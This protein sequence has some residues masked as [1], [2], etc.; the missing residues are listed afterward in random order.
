MPIYEYQCEE[1]DADFELFIRSLSQAAAPKCP[2]CGS[3]RV[4]KAISLFGVGRTSASGLGASC[5]PG[6][7]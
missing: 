1:C 3:H 4:K 2:Q 7:T 6:S 5:D